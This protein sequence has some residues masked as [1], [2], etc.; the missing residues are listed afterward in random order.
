MALL[1]AADPDDAC[2]GSMGAET[3]KGM[4]ACFIYQTFTR[5]LDQEDFEW[6]ANVFG[7]SAGVLGVYK[8]F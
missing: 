3:K 6:R 8:G 1:G 5:L 7:L 2:G 4:T